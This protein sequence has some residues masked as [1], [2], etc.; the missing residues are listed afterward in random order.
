[1]VSIAGGKLT[2]YRPMAHATLEQAA[3]H[4]GLTLAPPVPPEPLPGGEGAADLDALARS[5]SGVPA[6][7]AARLARAYGGEAAAVLARGARPLAP[8]ATVVEGE[9]DWAVEVEDALHLED[10][11]YRRTGAA[12]YDPVGREALVAPMVERMARRLGWDEG[13][14][15]A[16]VAAVRERL[17]ADLEFRNHSKGTASPALGLEERP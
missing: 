13:R 9:V 12:L 15:A 14:R 7:V 10:V 2:G 11:L 4:A 17:A 6:D 5:L 16:E 8:G 1:V 3:T